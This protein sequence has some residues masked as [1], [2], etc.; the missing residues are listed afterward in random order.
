MSRREMVRQIDRS[1]LCG[2]PGVEA[3]AIKDLQLVFLDLSHGLLFDLVQL[4]TWFRDGS[5][6][7]RWSC[8]ADWFGKVMYFDDFTSRGKSSERSGGISIETFWFLTSSVR[9]E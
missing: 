4:Q 5:C 6:E 8:L 1:G 2:F 7:P 3:P 9:D